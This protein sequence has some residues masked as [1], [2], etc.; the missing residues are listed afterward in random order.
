MPNKTY[1][2]VK[3][4]IDFAAQVGD[5]SGRLQNEILYS[6]ISKNASDKPSGASS[7]TDPHN[8]AV[9]LAKIYTWANDIFTFDPAGTKKIVIKDG[10][11][12][13]TTY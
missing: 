9:T 4:K 10:I 6:N 1:N 3:M 13:N 11:A 7:F 8:L 5:G 12:K 2:S